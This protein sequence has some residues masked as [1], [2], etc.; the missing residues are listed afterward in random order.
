MLPFW[1]HP[2]D[3]VVE[4][5]NSAESAEQ[6]D[7]NMDGKKRSMSC[8]LNIRRLGQITVKYDII[9]AWQCMRI[10]ICFIGGNNEKTHLRLSALAHGILAVPATSA[11]TERV[12]SI[13]GLVLQVKR[14]NLAPNKVNKV[15]FVHTVHI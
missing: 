15:V 5:A 6:R 11:P 1:I 2:R 10:K 13:A 8:W 7:G 4:F 9:D 12:F 14:S 3:G